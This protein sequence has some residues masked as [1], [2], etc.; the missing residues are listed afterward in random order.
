MQ[1]RSGFFWCLKGS[2]KFVKVENNSCK[3]NLGIADLGKFRDRRFWIGGT[4]DLFVCMISG[5]R[6]TLF[7]AKQNYID[8]IAS[9]RIVGLP[10]Q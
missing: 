6:N 10:W 2:V 7:W 9:S 3:W 5:T 4:L 8:I 1:C